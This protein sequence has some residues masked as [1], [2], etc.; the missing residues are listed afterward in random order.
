MIPESLLWRSLCATSGEDR[1]Q[2]QD[3]ERL[4]GR[5]VW[6]IAS[7]RDTSCEALPQSYSMRLS[8]GLP[9]RLYLWMPH[10]KPSMLKWIYC[11]LWEINQEGPHYPGFHVEP[12]AHSAAATAAGCNSNLCTFIDF[13]VFMHKKTGNHLFLSRILV[14]I[15]WV[16]NVL[17]VFIG[18][19]QTVHRSN[20]L[21]LSISTSPQS[22]HLKLVGVRNLVNV[23]HFNYASKPLHLPTWNKLP[24]RPLAKISHNVKST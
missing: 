13:L 10:S 15:R 9:V 12:G 19:L 1:G 18:L 24:F 5:E 20:S 23:F 3:G 22:N 21:C 17:A 4:L 7:G 2:A 6:S 16:R 14:E 11:L 8:P